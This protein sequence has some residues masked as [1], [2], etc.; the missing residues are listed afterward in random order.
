M[1]VEM[2]GVQAALVEATKAN[3]QQTKEHTEHIQ[4]LHADHVIQLNELRQQLE[5][6]TSAVEHVRAQMHAAECSYGEQVA[7]VCHVFLRKPQ[8]TAMVKHGVPELLRCGCVR[9]YANE[10]SVERCTSNGT[11]G[12]R[13]CRTSASKTIAR[14]VC[15]HSRC[16]C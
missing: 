8:L 14:R 6:S 11:I 3:E 15:A 7:Q 5:Q 1:S 9:M 12:M 13:Q 2:Q 16:A 4:R 10:I